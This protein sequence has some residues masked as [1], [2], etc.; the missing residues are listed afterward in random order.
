V[1]EGLK[2][3]YSRMLRP[4]V[5]LFVRLGIRPNHLTVAGVAAF[6]GVGVACALGHWY[7]AA[8]LAALGA[9]MDGWDGLLAREH[10]RSTRFGAV[11]DST[12]DRLTEILWTGGLL[13]FYLGQPQPP[14]GVCLCFAAISGS[15]MVSYVKARCEG[16]GVAC[17]EGLLQRPERIIL[18]G[19]CL[20][21]G[22]VLMLWGLGLLGLLAWIT[23]FQRLWIGYRRCVDASGSTH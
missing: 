4:G 18:L 5:K 14:V 16:A 1:I 23:V 12:C 6:G 13:V 15:L 21:C 7:T 10:G 19:L 9:F 2:P 3:A 22:P 20:F 8:G 11:L 17:G